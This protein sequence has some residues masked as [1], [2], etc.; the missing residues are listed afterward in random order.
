MSQ[1]YTTTEVARLLQMDG[2][3]IAKWVDKG[4]ITAYRTPGGHRRVRASELRAFLIANE[5]PI[6]QDLGSDHVNLMIIDDER[7]VLDSLRR[8]LRKYPQV[9]V[10]MESSGIEGLL[11]LA[12]AK[13]HGILLDLNLP[14][15]DGYEVCRAISSRKSLNGVKVVAFTV[16]PTPDVV[17]R[18]LK[19]GAVACL[20]KPLDVDR[21]LEIFKV[22]ISLARS[23]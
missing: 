17:N 4:F 8:S 2:S 7:A 1:L 10:S 21:L 9:H 11:S 3:T 22:P 23:A 20:A 5:M 14:D 19:A 12:E 15:L 6:P 16:R 13:P 18:A